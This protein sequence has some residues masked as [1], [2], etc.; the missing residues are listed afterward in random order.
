MISLGTPSLAGGLGT[1]A[2]GLGRVV[3]EEQIDLL[4]SEMLA[5]L[6]GERDS[7]ILGPLEGGQT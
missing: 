2:G 5:V 6:P 1:L 7:V 3:P 4:L